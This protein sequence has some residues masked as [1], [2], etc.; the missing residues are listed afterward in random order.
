MNGLSKRVIL[1]FYLDE[2]LEYN[3]TFNSFFIFILYQLYLRLQSVLLY[4]A[5]QYAEK[6]R[7]S[8]QLTWFSWWFFRIACGSEQNGHESNLWTK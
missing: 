5:T 1:V 8:I 6:H 7:M 2:F 4:I 3:C